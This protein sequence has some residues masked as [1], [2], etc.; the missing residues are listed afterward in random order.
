MA[1]CSGGSEVTSRFA[2]R[3]QLNAYDCS[4]V[5]VGSW[6][7]EVLGDTELRSGSWRCI[8]KGGARGACK[9]ESSPALL[10]LVAINQ[11][12]APGFRLGRCRIAFLVGA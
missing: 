5:F 8:R 10:S 2:V 3:A 12:L 9:F 11:S 1:V 6:F 4:G 7:E